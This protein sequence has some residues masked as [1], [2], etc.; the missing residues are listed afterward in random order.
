MT[1][2]ATDPTIKVLRL[3]PSVP[4]NMRTA[5]RT[6]TLP[7]GG[8]PDGSAPVLIHKGEAVGYCPY[9]MHRRTDIFG[10]DAQSFRPERW[11]E[12]DGKLATTVG[13]GYLPFNAG[14][15]LCLGRKSGNKKSLRLLQYNADNFFFLKIRGIRSARSRLPDRSP[16]P[17]VSNAE[18]YARRP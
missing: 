1:S 15:R 13:Y 7:T 5:N 9:I 14:P 4:I 11:L 3:Y 12:N 8:G 16:P 6:T 18:S 17:N 2:T 10:A